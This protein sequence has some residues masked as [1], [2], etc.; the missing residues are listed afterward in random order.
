MARQ[1]EGHQSTTTPAHGTHSVTV[2]ERQFI[3]DP[4]KRDDVTNIIA[5]PLVGGFRD[6]QAGVPSTILA[7]NNDKS[8]PDQRK[9]KGLKH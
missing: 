9:D 7:T 4:E 3:D 8:G 5:T 1:Q 2:R 6:R